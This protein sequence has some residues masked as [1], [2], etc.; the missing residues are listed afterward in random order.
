ML[1]TCMLLAPAAL[2]QEGTE[3]PDDI[4]GEPEESIA[5][6]TKSLAEGS[7][8]PETEIVKTRKP[9]IQTFQ[10]K[11]FLKLGR[12]E[13]GAST[14]L[15]T[16]DPFLNR[17]LFQGSV[18]YHITEVFG[19]EA[20]GGFSP[21]ATTRC[22]ERGE[23]ATCFDYKQ[24]TRQITTENQVT[25]DISRIFGY[26]YADLQ[27]SPIYGKVAVGNG[28]VNFDI[29]GLFGT[30]AVFTVDDIILSGADDS[31]TARQWHPMVNFGGGARII[32]SRSFAAR[33]EGRG[34][35]YI[36]TLEG[37][38]LEMKNNFAVMAGATVFFPGM[39]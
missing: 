14:G 25:P 17:I 6:E 19:I 32:F 9:V 8:E 10:P 35:S 16:N 2:A 1:L 31:T 30:G 13:L 3:L 24:I 36:E 37:T 22:A 15:I 28:I 7:T 11:D 34:L 23:E 38:T 4:F 20:V 21:G 27:F 12:Y 18:T 39:K 29:Y 26:A 33:I 5:E